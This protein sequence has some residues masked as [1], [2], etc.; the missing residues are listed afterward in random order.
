MKYL[1][2][3]SNEIGDEGF[4]SILSSINN[5]EK[6]EIGSQFDY[7]LTIKGIKALSAAV[8]NLSIPVSIRYIE[9]ES[10]QLKSHRFKQ[11]Y[12]VEV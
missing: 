7:D 1:D 6:L 4:I 8:S 10:Q 3:S 2:L 5:I 11:T 12:Q 9:L